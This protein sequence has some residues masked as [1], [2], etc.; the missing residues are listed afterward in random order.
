MSASDRRVRG[1]DAT[2]D[3]ATPVSLRILVESPKIEHSPA[4]RRPF[5]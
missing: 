4:Q 1:G 3:R 2:P 5:S